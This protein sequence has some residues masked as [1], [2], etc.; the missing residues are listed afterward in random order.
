MR[1]ALKMKNLMNRINLL[2]T[3]IGTMFLFTVAA[4]ASTFTVTNTN[5]SGFG[6]LRKA[7]DDANSNPGAD[8]IHFNIGGGGLHTIVPLTTFQALK[9]PLISMATQPGAKANTLAEGDDAAS[10]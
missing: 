1:I 5:D 9:T 4:Q 10:D 6:S 2:L 3:L 8:I 7:I